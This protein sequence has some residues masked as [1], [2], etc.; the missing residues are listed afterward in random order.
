MK[1]LLFLL[2]VAAVAAITYCVL[3]PFGPS[4]ETFVEI[5]PGTPTVQIG[6]LLKRSGVIRSGLAFEAMH[7]VKGGTLKAGEYRFDRPATMATVYNRLD[8]A[9]CTPW[10]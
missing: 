7:L 5:P 4:S 3:A 10:A 1:R 8:A 9:M 6:N 2:F